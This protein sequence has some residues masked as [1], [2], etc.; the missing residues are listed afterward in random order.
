M[1][2]GTKEGMKEGN[3]RFKWREMLCKYGKMKKK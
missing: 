2:E 3:G 1:K